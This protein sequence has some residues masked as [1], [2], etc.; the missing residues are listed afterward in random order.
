MVNPEPE[1]VPPV[2]AQL[3]VGVEVPVTT[4]VNVPV[5]PAGI[6]AGDG[7]TATVTMELGA[8]GPAWGVTV[9]TQDAEALP[10]AVVAVTV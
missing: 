7:D 1:I 5:L 10:S 9:T 2:A 3:I 6:A 8:G 4:A